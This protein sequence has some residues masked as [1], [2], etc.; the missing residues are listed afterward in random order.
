MWPNAHQDD[1]GD[2]PNFPSHVE[3]SWFPMKRKP[4]QSHWKG[5]NKQ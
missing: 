5:E 4:K 2:A 1:I 3:F